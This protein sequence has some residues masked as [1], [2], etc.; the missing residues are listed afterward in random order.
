MDS[1]HER[2][3]AWPDSVLFHDTLQLLSKN[4]ATLFIQPLKLEL[5]TWELFRLLCYNW[6]IYKDF[7][8]SH[9]IVQFSQMKLS[10]K[11]PSFLFSPLIIRECSPSWLLTQLSRINQN[12]RRLFCLLGSLH[13]QRL[14]VYVT[15]GMTRIESE[16]NLGP[17]PLKNTFS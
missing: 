12:S 5:E 11:P 10:E 4:L 1:K 7:W 16:S 6:S 13:L 15:P 17:W 3:G 8:S 9:F 2:V 14:L